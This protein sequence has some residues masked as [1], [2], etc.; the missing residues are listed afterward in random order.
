MGTESNKKEEVWGWGVDIKN[1]PTPVQPGSQG[2]FYCI[3]SA[4]A[5]PL[6]TLHPPH[7]FIVGSK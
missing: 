1:A 2:V 7:S 5:L 4:K 3:K 6:S